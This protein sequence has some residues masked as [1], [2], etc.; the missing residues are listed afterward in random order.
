MKFLQSVVGDKLT[1]P[2]FGFTLTVKDCPESP[3]EWAS[4]R[5]TV[6]KFLR[7]RGM[8]RYHWVT[9]W[10]ARGAPHLHG[11]VFFDPETFDL[12]VQGDFIQHWCRITAH[13]G[14]LSRGQ[15]ADWYRS[16]EGWAKYVSKHAGRGFSHYQRQADTLPK[17]WDN[18]GRMWGRGGDWPTAESKVELLPDEWH[19]FRR[20]VRSYVV[21][22]H[23]EVA[24]DAELWAS[25][26]RDPEKKSG[27]LVKAQAAW[28]RKRHAAKMLKRNNISEASVRPLSEWAGQGVTE[29]LLCHVTG[30]DDV[31]Q[32]GP[33]RD[34]LAMT[35]PRAPKAGGT[36]FPPHREP[37][38]AP[39][40]ASEP[41][42][43]WG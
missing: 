21:A 29:C 10:Q 2:G 6:L 35:A 34:R 43:P 8:I 20:L 31:G 5:D 11:V 25:R 19:R 30:V 32:I 3:D 33:S 27:H 9:E 15:H 38:R 41:S 36:C 1:E 7:R 4:L 37:E 13:L 39:E 22:R 23:R 14:T 17:G 28:R 42:S 12:E 26:T 18:A 16:W 24:L 40:P